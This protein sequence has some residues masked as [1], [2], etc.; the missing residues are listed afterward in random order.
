MSTANHGLAA[1]A[2]DELSPKPLKTVPV[3]HRNSEL[4][5]LV[6]SLQY[7]K[8]PSAREVEPGADVADGL[9]IRDYF[10]NDPGE[11]PSR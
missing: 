1:A 10:S 6:K 8:L 2:I 11:A 4:N 3:G 9:G 7:G 5:F